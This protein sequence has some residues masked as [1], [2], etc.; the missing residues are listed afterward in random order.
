MGRLGKT[1]TMSTRDFIS[2]DSAKAFLG[3][4]KPESSLAMS[5]TY[6]DDWSWKRVA[7]GSVLMSPSKVWVSVT[8]SSHVLD[9]K[10]GYKIT[11]CYNRIAIIYRYTVPSRLDVS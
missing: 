9:N 6:L 10:D 11:A 1:D 8:P 5:V 4:I 7:G 3:H 2:I